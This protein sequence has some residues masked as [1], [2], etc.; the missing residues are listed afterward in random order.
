MQT[1]G[2]VEKGIESEITEKDLKVLG[3]REKEDNIFNALQLIFKSKD[4]SVVGAFNNISSMKM[5]DFFLWIEE[6]IQLEYKY[7]A[8]KKAYDALSNADIYRKRIYR[9]QYWRFLVYINLFL[10]LGVA[11]AKEK[12]QTGFTKYR[13]PGRLLKIWWANK[14]AKTKNEIAEKI[15]KKTHIGKKRAKKD[16]DIF[17]IIFLYNKK[18]EKEEFVKFFNLSEEQ[19]E[20]LGG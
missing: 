8:L 14:K 11:L 15:A 10:T 20:Y 19:A 6:N 1:L 3:Y 17:K 5:D 7:E 12:P 9:R 2:C 4:N 16:F 13:R 18:K